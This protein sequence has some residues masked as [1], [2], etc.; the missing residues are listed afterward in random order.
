M[1]RVGKPRNR[2]IDAVKDDAKKILGIRNWRRK[3]L[4]GEAGLRRPSP[5]IGLPRYK[6]KNKKI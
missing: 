4:N 1:R 6:K 2:W 5:D 3:V